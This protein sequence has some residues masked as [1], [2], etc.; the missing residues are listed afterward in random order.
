MNLIRKYSLD[1]SQL[2]VIG[3]K[4]DLTNERRLSKED[5]MRLAASYG[6][7]FMETNVPQ[8]RNIQ[9]VFEKLAVNL[10]K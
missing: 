2:V 3:N 6:A 9:K 1:Q 4:T 5:G 8:K 7:K 10:S